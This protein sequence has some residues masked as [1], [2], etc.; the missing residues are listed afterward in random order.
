MSVGFK[1]GGWYTSNIINENTVLAICLQIHGI[2]VLEE[3]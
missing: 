3:G 2:L 1:V